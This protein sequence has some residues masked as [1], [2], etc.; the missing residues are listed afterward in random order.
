MLAKNKNLPQNDANVLFT[1]TVA[2]TPNDLSVQNEE[3]SSRIESM[4]LD[5]GMDTSMPISTS[6]IGHDLKIIRGEQVEIPQDQIVVSKIRC[7]LCG[8]LMEPNEAN[9]CFNCLKSKLDISEGISKRIQ[10]HHCKEC[11]RYMR[12]P[13]TQCDLESPQLLQ[14]CLKH[15]KGLSRVK[16]VD[17]AFIWTEPHSRQL[18]VKITIQKEVV[19]G[20]QV[21]QTFVIDFLVQNL[22]CEDCKRVYTP[23]LW[24]SQVQVR[25]KVDHKR[26]FL[27]LEQLVLKHNAAEKCSNIQCEEGGHGVNFQ[28]RHR[29]H[30]SR[31]VDF[32]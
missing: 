22:Q 1:P 18:K 7:C 26:T 4:N 8:T 2:S 13:W 15:I 3:M 27:F 6:S 23:H 17:A 29:S 16:L 21:Q 31:L 12:P 24:Q 14:L 30:A 32:I 19:S 10:L 25:Q 9:T 28:F 11:N 5:S 20:M